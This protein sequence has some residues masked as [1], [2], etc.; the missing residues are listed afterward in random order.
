VERAQIS[1]DL[2]LVPD[3]GRMRIDPAR[4]ERAVL[5]L[6]HNAIKFT[7]PGGKVTLT[8]QRNDAGLMVTVR[9]TGSGIAASDLPRIFERFYKADQSRASG[10]TGLGLALVKHAVEAHG[11]NVRVES[12]E[13]H[14]SCFSFT[15]PNDV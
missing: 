3:L 2:D 15:I 12:E 1:L 5:N 13:G 11:G 9:D 14:G 7:P 4:I 10:G 6:L 8:A